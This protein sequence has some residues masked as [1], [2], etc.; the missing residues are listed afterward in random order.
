MSEEQTN[1]IKEKILKDADEG[2]EN[3][4][5]GLI[6]NKPKGKLPEP[7]FRE[8]YLKY[9]TGEIPMEE[10][11]SIIAEWVGIAGSP[12]SE[13]DIVGPDGKT[14]LTVPPL[15][16]TDVIDPVRDNSENSFSNIISNYMLKSNNIPAAADRY[17]ENELDKKKESVAKTKSNNI[18]KWEKILDHYGVK[19]NNN[20]EINN[21]NNEAD[22]SDN[23]LDFDD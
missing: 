20:V 16:N 7:L 18:A 10:D 2:M 23:D 15:F 19:A 12:G 9:F 13:V 17:L 11:T 14:I 1:T 6:D 3:V 22:I 5:N 8:H 21:P 4:F